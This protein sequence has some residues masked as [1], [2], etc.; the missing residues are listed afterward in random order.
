MVVARLPA[1]AG[2]SLAPGSYRVM[3]DSKPGA[4][5]FGLTIDMKLP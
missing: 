4:G 5:G 2:V 1:G 3:F